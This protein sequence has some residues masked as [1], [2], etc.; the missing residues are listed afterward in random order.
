[1]D[2]CVNNTPIKYVDPTGKLW[3]TKDIEIAGKLS[4]SDAGDFEDAIMK[5]TKDFK[6]AQGNLFFQNKA[7]YDASVVRD[8]YYRLACV[9]VYVDEHDYTYGK[10]VLVFV[11]SH[12]VADTK[13]ILRH[14]S[15][16]IFASAAS[17]FY[18]NKRFDYRESTFGRNVKYATIGAGP[19]NNKLVCEYN[20]WKDLDLNIKKEMIYLEQANETTV[21]LLF[22]AAD[23]YKRNDAVDYDA[24]VMTGY[25]S[26]SFINGLLRAAGINVLPNMRPAMAWGWDTA[27]PNSK[28]Q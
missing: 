13:N 10:K 8:Y 9:G 22:V 12:G 23:N 20:R 4:A 1:M 17:K 18:N 3:T 16:I 26:N 19:I 28:F 21:D 2:L 24:A 6:N 14:T 11:G 5:A 25:N 27:V 7:A 15:I